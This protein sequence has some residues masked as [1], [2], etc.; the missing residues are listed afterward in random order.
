MRPGLFHCRG[1]AIPKPHSREKCIDALPITL[2]ERVC[3]APVN[4]EAMK[5]SDA[6]DCPSCG[7]PMERKRTEV[8]PGG[9]IL[10]VYK[11]VMCN[12]EVGKLAKAENKAK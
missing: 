7:A 8:T 4:S 10:T 11:C 9:V 5:T 6:M 1:L 12:T 3:M 2:T